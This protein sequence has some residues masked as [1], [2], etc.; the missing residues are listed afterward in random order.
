[1]HLSS[2]LCRTQQIFHRDRAANSSLV[3]IRLIA[4]AAAAAWEREALAAESREGRQ[5][6]AC[7]L[8]APAY[9]PQSS[10]EFDRL[11]SENPDREYPND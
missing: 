10:Q 5:T 7:A 3:N 1:M 6:R 4:S 9:A 2:A 8:P 11:C